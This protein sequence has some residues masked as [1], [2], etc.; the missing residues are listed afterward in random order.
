MERQ[1]KLRLLFDVICK[2]VEVKVEVTNTEKASEIL[3][4]IVDEVLPLCGAA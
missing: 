1:D 4:Q 3:E 2:P